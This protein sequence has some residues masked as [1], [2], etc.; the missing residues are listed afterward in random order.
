MLETGEASGRYRVDLVRKYGFRWISEDL[1]R[2]GEMCQDLVRSG[3]VPGWPVPHPV[4]DD[5]AAI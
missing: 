1:V 4:W 3:I 5:G 2:S